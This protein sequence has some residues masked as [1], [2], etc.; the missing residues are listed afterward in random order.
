[1]SPAS[2]VILE[3]NYNSAKHPH[4]FKPSG[5]GY[6]NDAILSLIFLC[7]N[8]L[9][10]KSKCAG[11]SIRETFSEDQKQLPKHRRQQIEQQPDTTV[12]GER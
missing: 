11:P 4:A 8:I 2:R 9:R 12:E 1:M 7:N 6:L 5:R 10:G 3:Q